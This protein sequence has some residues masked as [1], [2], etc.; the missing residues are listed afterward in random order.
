MILEKKMKSGALSCQF[1]DIAKIYWILSKIGAISFETIILNLPYTY[2]SKYGNKV[3]RNWFDRS[4][5]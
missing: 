1:L 5:I 3:Q 4:M 2:M